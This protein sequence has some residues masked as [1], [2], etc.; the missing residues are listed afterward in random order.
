VT[1]VDIA[2]PNFIGIGNITDYAFDVATQ[3]Y[4]TA[5]SVGQQTQPLLN[6]QM[7]F[8]DPNVAAPVAVLS[9]LVAGEHAQ[10]AILSDRG[11]LQYW[12]RQGGPWY[13]EDGFSF[14]IDEFYLREQL[15][16]DRY[17]QD[18]Q[19]LEQRG[20]YRQWSRHF[21]QHARD[22]RSSGT[23]SDGLMALIQDAGDGCLAPPTGGLFDLTAMRPL[24]MP[25]T[26]RRWTVAF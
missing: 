7:W 2:E 1:T 5:E 23:S 18:C 16:A 22:S 17:R 3:R 8:A 4:V 6:L 14:P 20:M 26:A 9:S 12:L 10:F 24:F 25:S 13:P 21:A 11:D 19:V 15:P